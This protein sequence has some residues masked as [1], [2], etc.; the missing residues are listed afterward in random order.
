[1]LRICVTCCGLK[2]ELQRQKL[3]ADTKNKW[4]KSFTSRWRK[5]KN[6]NNFSGQK[7]VHPQTF[8]FFHCLFIQL[9]I[10]SVTRQQFHQNGTGKELKGLSMWILH[11]T[12]CGSTV[13]FLLNN[14]PKKTNLLWVRGKLCE[15]KYFVDLR[16]LESE[17]VDQL[18]TVEQAMVTHL[19]SGDN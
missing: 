6:N 2:N 16:R 11:S 10:Q 15:G 17:W 8:S 9:A 7:V 19:S 12:N 13:I 3:A 14:H 18:A 5:K 4:K 1:M